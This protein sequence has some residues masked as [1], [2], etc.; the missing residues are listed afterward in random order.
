MSLDFSQQKL[1]F[2]AIQKSIISESFFLIKQT[3]PNQ[4]MIKDQVKER[5]YIVDVEE[6]WQIINDVQFYG[7]VDC[8]KTPRFDL[9]ERPYYLRHDLSLVN[10]QDEKHKVLVENSGD[11]EF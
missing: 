7:H 2:K 11:V 4:L 1:T 8:F 5:L 9:I 6:A 10:C 3:I